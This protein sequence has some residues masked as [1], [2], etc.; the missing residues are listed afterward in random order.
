MLTI[1]RL[2][3]KRFARDK[4]W[5]G[6]PGLLHRPR[7]LCCY[8]QKWYLCLTTFSG[9]SPVISTLDSGIN[10]VH[11]SLRRPLFQNG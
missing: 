3:L 7:I 9:P 11:T 4:G 10:H 1:K 5:N 2:Q 6:P 8:K